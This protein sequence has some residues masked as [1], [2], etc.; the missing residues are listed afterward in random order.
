STSMGSRA[1]NRWTV[2][3]RRASP[4]SAAVF[5][6]R[7]L[8]EETFEAAKEEVEALIRLTLA[9]LPGVDYEMHDL[10]VVPPVS[11]PDGSPVVS[12]LDAA[13]RRVLGAPAR[14]VASPG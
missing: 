1:V 2:F 12:A 13:I 3:K 7:F 5:D 9:G 4:M 10:M 6:R 11:T 8:I 14:L